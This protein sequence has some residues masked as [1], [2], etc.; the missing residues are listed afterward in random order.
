MCLV[1]LAPFIVVAT[2][3]ALHGAS[4]GARLPEFWLQLCCTLAVGPR[5]VT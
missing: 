4:S 1:S 3:D 5:Q 2:W